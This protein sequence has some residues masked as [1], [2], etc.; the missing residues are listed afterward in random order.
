MK[1]PVE[2][3]RISQ[4]GKEILINVKRKTGIDQ[5]NILCRWALSASLAVETPPKLKHGSE[6]SNVEIAWKVFG[7]QMSDLFAVLLKARRNLDLRDS[8]LSDADYFKAHLERGIGYLQ[9][10]KSL[11]HLCGWHSGFTG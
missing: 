10:V 5:W 9:N 2:T 8:K 4:R 3:V 7:G 11:E 1:P 6:E